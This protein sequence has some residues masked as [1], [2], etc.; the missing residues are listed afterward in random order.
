MSISTMLEK[1]DTGKLILRLT[2]GV[3][4]L[5]HGAMKVQSPSTFEFIAGTLSSSGIPSFI[6]YGVYVGEILAPLLIVLGVFTRYSAMLIIINMVFAI[7]L[8]HSGDIF[9]LSDHGG[10]RLELQGF[11]MFTAAAIVFLGSGQYAI[12]PD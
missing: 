12:K 4:M 5:F 9:A 3:L 8:M 7:F 1:E 10:W 6:A 2:V 11:F